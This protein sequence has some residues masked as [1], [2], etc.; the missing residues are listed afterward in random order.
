MFLLAVCCGWQSKNFAKIAKRTGHKLDL[1]QQ[2]KVGQVEVWFWFFS[3]EL[4]NQVQELV[5]L[6]S[7]AT[8]LRQIS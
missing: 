6:V 8:I 7:R 4:S 1:H 3:K 5:L 2:V